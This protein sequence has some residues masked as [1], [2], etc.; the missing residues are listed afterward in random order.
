MFGDLGSLKP[1]G[2]RSAKQDKSLWLGFRVCGLRVPDLQLDLSSIDVNQTGPEFNS[3]SQI[4]I[5]SESLVREL[6]E[7][8][9]LPYSYIPPN[10]HKN[11][12]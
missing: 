7:E 8:T 12:P 2:I 10:N 3:N 1:Y 4:M 5:S 6:Q 9:A 11:K